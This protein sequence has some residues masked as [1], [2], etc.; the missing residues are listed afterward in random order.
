M[1]TTDTLAGSSQYHP[2][3]KWIDREAERYRNGEEADK[4]FTYKPAERNHNR[5][6]CAFVVNRI[7]ELEEKQR[8]LE[9]RLELYESPSALP[10]K[11]VGNL[12]T[13]QQRIAQLNEL[14]TRDP[15]VASPALREL[16]RQAPGVIQERIKYILSLETDVKKEAAEKASL[17][18]AEEEAQRHLRR[19][20]AERLRLQEELS[21]ASQKLSIQGKELELLRVT[22]SPVSADSNS[23]NIKLQFQAKALEKERDG[24]TRQIQNLTRQLEEKE[25][26]ISKL[27]K[28]I[29]SLQEQAEAPEDSEGGDASG[30]ED[31]EDTVTL[32][33]PAPPPYDDAADRRRATALARS[34]ALAL[35]REKYPGWDLKSEAEKEAI[36][37]EEANSPE[38]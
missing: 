18:R 7:A 29:A 11:S 31:A 34:E 30:E 15:G 10:T 13:L 26:I 1:S 12:T 36:R 37:E 6:E 19:E 23:E 14:A 9:K 3:Y 27:E 32:S 22:P 38:E 8:E 20:V 5:R 24:K 4:D 2:N 17:Q 21:T 28:R 35:F 25:S 16:N 33:A